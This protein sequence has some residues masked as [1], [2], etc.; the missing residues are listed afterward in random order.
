MLDATIDSLADD[1]EM[2]GDWEQRYEYIAEL[3]E[4]LGELSEAD[5]HDGSKVHGC[6]SNVYVVGEL[7]D[8]PP[9]TIRYRAE[10]D[11]A[12]IRGVI[13]I[14]LMIYKDRTPQEALE[15]D[16]DQ[17]FDRLGLFD[18]LSPT[19]HVGIYAIVERI[20]AVARELDAA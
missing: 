2:L 20:R 1:F 16:A 8:D 5:R 18:H 6:M 13:A 10:C 12:I 11:T 14:L 17:L 4:T 9:G 3:G 19:R 15:V 7:S